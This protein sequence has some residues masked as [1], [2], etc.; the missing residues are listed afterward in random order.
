MPPLRKI[1]IDGHT[2]AAL[3]FN[4]EREGLPVVLIHGIIAS[5]YFWSTDLLAPFLGVG[6]CY[7]LSLPG[8]YPAAFPE[9]LSMESLTAAELARLLTSAIRELVGDERPLLV[10]HSTG[11]F[12]VLD[13]AAH[14]P[15]LPRNV[16]SI[17][18]FAHGRWTGLLGTYQ[19]L[20]RHGLP[21]RTMFKSLFR[22]GRR[23]GI[24]YQAGRFYVHDPARILA[25]PHFDEMMGTNLAAFRKLALDDVLKYFTVMPDVDITPLLGRIRVPTL[26]LT[27][28]RD[29]IVPPEQSR[30]IAREVP[31]A[32]LATIEETGHFPFFES[33]EE[34]RAIVDSWLEEQV[35]GA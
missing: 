27:G 6:P 34:Y 8:H 22:V 23:R 31:D 29:P 33:P 18:G 1:E 5:V 7:A 11:G 2:L 13:V 24:Y 15:D 9:D 19:W 10:G 3:A 32:D 17:S 14:A 35:V 20:A 21:G 4:P 12:A 25:Y 16:I 30:I 28:T 26:A